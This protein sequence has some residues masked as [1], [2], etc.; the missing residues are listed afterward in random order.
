MLAAA[1]APAAA[2]AIELTLL[3]QHT[4]YESVERYPSGAVADR[5]SASLDRGFALRARAGSFWLRYDGWRGAVD[6]RGSNFIGF[7]VFTTTGLDWRDGATG[8]GRRL[9]S[10]DGLSLDGELGAGWRSMARAIAPS[11]LSSALDETLACP[12]L[13]LA[14]VLRW[15]AAERIGVEARFGLQR[16]LACRLKVDFH[17]VY[18][19]MSLSPAGSWSRLAELDL[20]LKLTPRLSAVAG[21]AGASLQTG[22]SAAQPYRVAGVASATN[23]FYPGSHQ[24]INRL[25]LGIRLELP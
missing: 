2:S 15:R 9:W 14:P 16:S 23:L 11:P 5:D 1:L 10:G 8:L 19:P 6:Y 4:R 3:A 21:W 7:P 12:Y 17:G 18:D 22:P 20:S 24:A 25:L 13:E